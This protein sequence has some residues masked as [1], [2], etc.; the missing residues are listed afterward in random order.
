M[1]DDSD[2]HNLL[3]SLADGHAASPR[4][5]IV[6]SIDQVRKKIDQVSPIVIHLR[7]IWIRIA[8]R[9]CGTNQNQSGDKSES[10]RIVT[11]GCGRL[12]S[13]KATTS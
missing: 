10:I 1:P 3:P 4:E 9:D 2:S 11:R 13:E 7:N 6:H 5:I 8:T 12:A